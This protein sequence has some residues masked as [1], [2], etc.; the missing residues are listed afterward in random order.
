MQSPVLAQRGR[1][2]ID[3]QAGIGKA[4]GQLH[5]TMEL[6]MARRGVTAET[7]PADMDA[8]HD[9]IDQ[10][11][12]DFEPYRVRQLLGEWASKNHGTTC[13]QAFEEIQDE[14]VPQLKALD[15]GPTTLEYGNGAPAPSYFTKVWFHRTTGG[16]DASDYNG[17]VHG[18]LVHK[19][20]VAKAY[21]GDIFAQR[22]MAAKQAPRRDY[23]RILDMGASSGHYTMALAEAY[24]NAEITGIDLSPRMLEHARRVANEHGYA[25]KLA[26]RPAEDTGYEAGSFDLV[27][28]FIVFHELPSRIIR[29][30]L[31]EAFRLLEPGG[32]MVMTDVPRYQ[33]M[34]RL[35]VWRYDWLAK[36]GG[37][38]YWRASASMD[39][40]A[41]AKEIGFEMVEGFTQ[42]PVHTYYVLRA[43]KPL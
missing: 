35:S 31:E 21:P 37:E 36:W 23:K 11:L 20:L 26:V 43:R 4:T 13:R 28:S 15:D 18:E 41:A 22:K 25:W 8:A 33:D 32:D 16:W 40:I 17:Y 14:L 6:E 19:M 3:F 34:D 38:P 7:L 24:P 1:A 29:E 42:E 2:S 39:L 12:S 10:R 9:L 5:Q 30:I 27:T